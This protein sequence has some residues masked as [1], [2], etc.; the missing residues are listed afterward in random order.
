MAKHQHLTTNTKPS[1]HVNPSRTPAGTPLRAK[2]GS[3]DP[4]D[5]YRALDMQPAENANRQAD[6]N[7]GG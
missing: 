7:N 4:K 6:Q 5:K 3:R 2:P 1:H